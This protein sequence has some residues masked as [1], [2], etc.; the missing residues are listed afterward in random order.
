MSD[1]KSFRGLGLCFLLVLFAMGIC[2][3]VHAEEGGE[4]LIIFT[5]N[6][7]GDKSD[8]QI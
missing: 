5:E 6:S 1:G 8:G 3:H 4:G 2:A 7:S